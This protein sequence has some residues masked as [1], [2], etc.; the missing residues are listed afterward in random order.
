[1]SRAV[2]VEAHAKLNLGLAVGPRRPDGYHEIATFYQSV[3][4][5]DTLVFEPRREGFTLAVRSE[6]PEDGGAVGSIPRGAGNLVSAAARLMRDEIGIRGARIRLVKRIPAGSGLGGASADAAATIL[7][8]ARLH[9]ARLSRERRMALGLRLGSDVPFALLGGTALGLGRGERLRP[10]RLKERFRAIVAVPTWRVSTALAFRRIDHAK[11]GLTAWRAKLRFAQAIEREG[12]TTLDGKRF[13]NTFEL[14]LGNRRADLQSLRRR[15]TAAGL[16]RPA[17]TGSGS[18]V[19][20]I[21]PAGVSAKVA[22]GRFE[23]TERLYV[24]HSASAGARI[25]AR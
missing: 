3:S 20:G 2:R 13:G 11:Y 12:V 1:M 24:V 18:A 8:L 17:L 22:I 4:L 19:F 5:A 10:L 15:M 16:R 14:A 25:A 9:G 6:L 21:L 23:G 7:G